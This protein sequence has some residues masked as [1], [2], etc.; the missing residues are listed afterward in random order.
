[1]TRF[2]GSVEKC[3]LGIGRSLIDTEA[4]FARGDKIIWHADM[5][6][7]YC[8]GKEFKGRSGLHFVAEWIPP[9]YFDILWGYDKKGRRTG[10]VGIK[11]WCLSG[12]LQQT[13]WLLSRQHPLN[14]SLRAI[15]IFN[16]GERDRKMR[17]EDLSDEGHDEPPEVIKAKR[18]LAKRFLRGENMR[19]PY[20][21]WKHALPDKNSWN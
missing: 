5:Q 21:I 14:A 8:M 15:D 11:F 17:Y 6:L 10:I 13:N 1:M 20:R 19:V 12:L 9:G 7:L 4:A 16:A 3:V 2:E 18:K